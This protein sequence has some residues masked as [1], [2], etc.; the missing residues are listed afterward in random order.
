MAVVNLVCPNKL[1]RQRHTVSDTETLVC[2][3]CGTLIQVAVEG[4]RYQK[5][6]ERLNRQQARSKKLHELITKLHLKPLAGIGVLGFLLRPLGFYI[7]ILFIPIVLWSLYASA[8]K[9]SYA[10]FSRFISVGI[11]FFVVGSIARDIVQPPTARCN[12]GTYSYSAHHRGTCSWHH[13]V[14]EWSPSPWWE[15]WEQ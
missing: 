4:E 12:D 13:G 5:E 14:G 8:R 1:C 3:S 10:S 2:S 6:L 15:A 11:L 7:A 9:R